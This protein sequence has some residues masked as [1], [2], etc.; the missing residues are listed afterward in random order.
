MTRAR[1]R[2]RPSKPARIRVPAAFLFNAMHIRYL[3]E[4]DRFN[5][6]FGVRRG[7]SPGLAPIIRHRFAAHVPHPPLPAASPVVSA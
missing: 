1:M 2:D 3:G 6:A 7:F 5:S 4:K